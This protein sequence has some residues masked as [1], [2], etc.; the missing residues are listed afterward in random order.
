MDLLLSAGS[1]GGSGLCRQPYTAFCPAPRAV[2]PPGFLACSQLIVCILAENRRHFNGQLAENG[3]K[4]RRRDAPPGSARRQSL[5]TEN[6]CRLWPAN[7]SP[8][9]GLC[10][11]KGPLGRP[12]HTSPPLHFTLNRFVYSLSAPRHAGRSFYLSLCTVSVVP[13]IR[14]SMSFPML[15]PP[16]P[17]QE[18]TNILYPMPREGKE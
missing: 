9:G 11:V 5:R 3:I 15:L 14:S 4:N 2:S 12:L 1:A 17:P 16:S 18:K 6:I 13:K 7:I 10:D 8:A